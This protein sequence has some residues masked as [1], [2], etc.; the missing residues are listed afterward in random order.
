MTDYSRYEFIKVEK[1]GKLATLTLNRPES[2]NAIHPPFHRELHQG[3]P[4]QTQKSLLLN[5]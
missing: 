5:R 2:L 4:D 1:E 3:Q